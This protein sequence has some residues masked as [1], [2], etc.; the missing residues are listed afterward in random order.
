MER[1]EGRKREPQ[2]DG[3]HLYINNGG[4]YVGCCCDEP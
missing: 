3:F 1:T 2:K 4:K